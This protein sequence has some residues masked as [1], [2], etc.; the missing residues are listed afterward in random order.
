MAYP[1]R[2]IFSRLPEA[3]YQDSSTVDHL[4]EW[5]DTKLSEKAVQM[6]LLYRDLCDPDSCKPEWL[7]Y[8][9][10]LVGLSGKFWDTEWPTQVK[11]TLIKNSHTILWSKRGTYEAIKFVLDAH[12]IEHQIWTDGESVLS[13]R[14]PKQFG[15]AK[16]R[17]FVRVPLK[18]NKQDRVFREAQRTL[19]NFAPAITKNAVVYDTFRLGFSSYG[20]PMFNPGTF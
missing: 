3:G 11:R 16:L 2:P 1:T 18:Y 14:M 7:D 8:L 10:Y 4:T 15:S 5:V 6:Q 9:A 20:D 19:R 12:E 13:F 17:F